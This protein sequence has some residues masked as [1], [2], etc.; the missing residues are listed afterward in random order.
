[1]KIAMNRTS[2]WVAWGLLA[3]A[4][5]GLAWR[6]GELEQTPAATFVAAALA[7]ALA[8][9]PVTRRAL[10]RAGAWWIALS[11]KRP[12]ATAFGVGLAG[13]AVLVAVAFAQQRVLIPQWHDEMSY[14]IQAQTIAGGR[15]WLPAHPLGEAV[16]SF[17][18]FTDR[19]T[20][21]S[22]SPGPGSSTRRACGL[23]CRIG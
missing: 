7:M 23:A 13:T 8:A 10:L 16:S 19:C 3:A 1:M 18:V 9:L 14:A 4:G 20:P 6:Y 5:L 15:L 11:R 12:G 22:T 21:R 2:G 17:Y